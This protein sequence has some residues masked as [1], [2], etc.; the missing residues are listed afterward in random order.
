M[1]YPQTERLARP[2]GTPISPAMDD[3]VCIESLKTVLTGWFSQHR[4]MRCFLAV[5]PSQRD[6]ISD[7]V[8]A[9]AS[10]SSLPRANVVIDHDGFPE[11]HR[12]YLLELDL[13]TPAGVDTLAQSVR[14]AYEDRHPESMAKGLGQR[15]GGWLASY[16]SLDE[17]AAHWSRLVLQRDDSGHACVL[18]FYDSR[19]LALLWPVL[20]QAQQQAMLGPVRAWHVLDSGARPSVHVASQESRGNF[21]LSAA[22]WQEIHRH[23]LVNRAL[24]LHAKE[25]GRQPEPDEIEAAVAAAARAERYRLVDRNDR[26]AFIGHALAWHPQFDLHPKVLQLLGR[27]AADAFYTA[28]IGQLTADEI[29]EIRQGSWHERPGTLASR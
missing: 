20:S 6:L 28:E 4:G 9:S 18:R 23:G 7:D 26:V 27:R 5:D 16:S 13:S 22:Q 14:V 8:E 17:V 3:D 10:F 12:P 24:A 21:M 19:A 11:A 15:A 29:D 1:E 2:E 25:C